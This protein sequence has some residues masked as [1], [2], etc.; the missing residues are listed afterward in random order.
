MS[1]VI[2][3]PRRANFVRGR[4]AA[5]GFGLPLV[6]LLLLTAGADLLPLSDPN[7]QDLSSSLLAP[8]VN[9][10]HP[11]GTDQLGR[12]MLSRHLYGARLSILIGVV[13]IVLG[14]ILGTA[15]GL[16]AGYYRGIADVVVSR[17]IDAQLA[18]PFVLLAI[19]LITSHGRSL[20]ILLVVLALF[21]WAQYAR[22]V[23]AETLALRERPFVL[24]LKAGGVSG[25]GIL[26]RH[27]LPNQGGT[28]LVLATLQ[29]GAVMLAEGALS[30]LGL[31]VVSPDISWGAMLADGKDQIVYAWWIAALPGLAIFLTVLLVNLL[32]DALRSILDPRRKRY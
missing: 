29:L 12:D 27:L 20:T 19:A 15:L 7:L 23:R 4:G 1:A 30:F 6:A 14:A 2:I 17:L 9:A 24:A 31:G 21:S 8:G 26:L 13:A 5:L 16:I 22:V 18:I 32:G 11:L 28:V 3:E 25:P 10:A